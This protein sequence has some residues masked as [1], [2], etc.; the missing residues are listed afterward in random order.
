MGDE[1]PLNSGNAIN[2]RKYTFTLQNIENGEKAWVTIKINGVTQ[3]CG[4]R[5]SSA[6]KAGVVGVGGGV[7]GGAGIGALAGGIG[8]GPGAV[9]GAVIGGL[10][11]VI[12]GAFNPR[13]QLGIAKGGK[14]ECR[15]VAMI[16]EEFLSETAISVRWTVP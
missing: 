12:Y 11:G 2:A 3:R 6:F 5:L 1:L 9:G 16:V 10:G 7:A 13:Y 4:D 8:A 15:G 14:S